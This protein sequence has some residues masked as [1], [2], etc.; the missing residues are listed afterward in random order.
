MTSRRGAPRRMAALAAV[1]LAAVLAVALVGREAAGL[2]LRFAAW[3]QD[4]GGWGP[5]AFVA[6]YVLACVALVPGSLLTLAAGLLFGLVRGTLYVLAGATLGATAAFLVARHL[7]RGRVARWV[8][9]DARLAA[10]DRAVGREGWRLVLLLRLSPV[11]PFS[12]LNYA[13]GLTRIPL[14]P[15]VL[16]SIGMVPG[17][18][19]YVYSG[20][21]LRGLA[22]LRAG[23]A[24]PRGAGYWAVLA[25][26]LAATALVTLLLARAARRALARST[27]GELG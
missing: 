10:V 1:V 16:A 19:L 21:L 8:A 5:A 14:G 7:A 18:V 13:L 15:Y 9:R 6:G 2:V 20:T 23:A 17:T 25:L 24:V 11:V 12:L 3:V 27:E 4:L 26:G 22:D